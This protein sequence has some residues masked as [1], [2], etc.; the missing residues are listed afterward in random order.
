MQGEMAMTTS[1]LAG[2]RWRTASFGE[3]AD[4]QSMELADLGEHLSKCRRSNGRLVALQC[5]GQATSGFVHSRL[6]TTLVV[7]AAVASI[8]YVLS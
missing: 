4:T 6:V 7:V 5:F 8:S 2:S 3:V 1:N